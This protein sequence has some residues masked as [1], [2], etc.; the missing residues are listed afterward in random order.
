ML[1][2]VS[3]KGMDRQSAYDESMRLLA[4]MG[5][6]DRALAYPSEISG[7]QKQR[8][9][10]ARALAM[11]PQVLLFDEP[12]SALDPTMVGEVLSVIRRLAEAGMTMVIV[13]HEM[14]FAR[15]VSTRV[16]YLDEGAV[17]EE[18]TPQQVFGS[19]EHERTRAFIKHLKVF[20]YSI[21][22]L[23]FDFVGMNNAIEG[24][25]E[26]HA[27]SRKRMNAVLRCVEELGIQTILPVTL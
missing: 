18:G 15:D 20:E 26:A 5:L 23:G 4:S 1:A 3:L 19:P 9:A 12:T 6:E 16:L 21:D 7:G 14:Q 17:Y 24:F 13:T 8:A 27:F 11:H 22:S 25:C 10:I 2:P